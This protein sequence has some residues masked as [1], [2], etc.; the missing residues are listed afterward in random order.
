[1]ETLFRGWLAAYHQDHRVTFN[2]GKSVFQNDN[3]AGDSQAEDTWIFPS[4]QM[5]PF[6][7]QHD[8]HLT[9]RFLQSGVQGALFKMSTG[10]FNLTNTYQNVILNRS[11][12]HLCHYHSDKKVLF[13]VLP[14]KEWHASGLQISKN[15]IAGTYFSNIRIEGCATDF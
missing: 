14:P 9:Q 1:M 4:I 7:I 13:E 15:C 8:S 5:G 11:L 6:D 12:P 10:Y 2:G 3:A